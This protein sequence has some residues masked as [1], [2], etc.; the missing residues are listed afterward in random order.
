MSVKLKNQA[1]Q[2]RRFWSRLASR[3]GLC[4]PW[5][6]RFACKP[7]SR[8]IWSYVKMPENQLSLSNYF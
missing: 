1:L 4:T 2:N 6:G 3:L 5:L 7:V 8:M